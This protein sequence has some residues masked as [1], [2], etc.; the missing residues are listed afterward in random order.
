MLFA[1]INRLAAAGLGAAN[2]FV[3]TVLV[4]D[5]LTAIVGL[6]GFLFIREW[7]VVVV[8]LLMMYF[9]PKIYPFV[10]IPPLG[11]GA[12]A[13]TAFEKGWALVGFAPGIISEANSV[14]SGVMS[15]RGRSFDVL[16]RSRAAVGSPGLT[17]LMTSCEM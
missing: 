13:F 17:S 10:V 4:F 15:S 16:S 8:G 7:L 2:I 1:G 9:M 6:I 5:V 12:L 11:L 3:T 14:T